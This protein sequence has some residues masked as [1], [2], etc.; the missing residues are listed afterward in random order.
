MHFSKIQAEKWLAAEST[1]HE[2]GLVS[3]Y[4][5]VP[6]AATPRMTGSD[7]K[8]WQRLQVRENSF[9]FTWL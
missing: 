3:T 2:Q 8:A 7:W 4:D 9:V 1:R 6:V 5:R